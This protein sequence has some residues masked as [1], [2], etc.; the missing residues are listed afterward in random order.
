MRASLQGNG[1][2][3]NLKLYLDEKCKVL[4][5][6]S[7]MPWISTFVVTNLAAFVR[8]VLNVVVSRVRE[9]VGLSVS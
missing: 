3:E 1:L 5:L 8:R 2:I 7:E 4:N 9:F 6:D